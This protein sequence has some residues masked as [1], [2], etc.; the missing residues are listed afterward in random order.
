[1]K[2][3]NRL[4]D[5]PQN[6]TNGSLQCL[7]YP[8][9]RI[10]MADDEAYRSELNAEVLRRHNYAVKTIRDGEAGWEELQTNHY[11]LLITESDLPGLTGVG[12]IKKLHSAG[13]PLPVIVATGIL[14]GWESPEYPWLLKAV[15]LLK[16][17]TLEEL[18]G[19]VKNVL[20]ATSRTRSQLTPPPWQIT[21]RTNRLRF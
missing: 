20:A 15:K 4:P 10:L 18:L 12:L 3:Q 17:Y 7:P 16:P 2:I 21:R 6:L 11:H 5:Q 9:C 19:I 13:M 8:H 1:M 14:P